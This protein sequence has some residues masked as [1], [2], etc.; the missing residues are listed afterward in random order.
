MKKSLLHTNKILEFYKFLK[1]LA[2]LNKKLPVNKKINYQFT[3]AKV[4]WYSMTKEGYKTYRDDLLVNRDKI[5][6]NSIIT[7]LSQRKN[8]QKCLVIM[9]FGHAM[10]L[11]KITPIPEWKSTYNYLKEN[12]KERASNVL[13]NSRIFGAF[14]PIANGIWDEAFRKNGNNQV[15]FNFEN[16]VFGEDNFDMMN[17]LRISISPFNVD[18][19][20]NAFNNVKYKDV[21]DGFVF[22]NPIEK[23]YYEEGIPGYSNSFET[24]LLRRCKLLDDDGQIYRIAENDIHEKSE[25]PITRKINGALIIEKLIELGLFLL[26]SIGFFISII[27]FVFFRKK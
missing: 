15:G 24:E 17:Y 11:L 27:V 6:A 26:F 19:Y 4:D 14:P 3:D 25:F 8:H 20:G 13:I 5:M 12:F 23:Q 21:F 10:N 9:N 1:K 22:I 18:F 7:D 16:T 2:L